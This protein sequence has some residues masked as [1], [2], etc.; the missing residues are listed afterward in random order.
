[1]F[2]RPIAMIRR[3]PESTEELISLF[4]NLLSF[5]PTVLSTHLQGALNEYG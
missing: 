2:R 4:R 5:A 1:M 3:D